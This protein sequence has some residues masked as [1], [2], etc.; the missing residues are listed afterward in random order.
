ML[1]IRDFYLP[2]T[3]FRVGN[4]FSHV[5]LSFCLQWVWGGG[6]L[7]VQGS[8]SSSPSPYRVLAPA[9]TLVRVPA[10]DPCLH[11]SGH[12]QTCSTWTTLYRYS[13]PDMFKFVHKKHVGKR[14][15]GILLECFPVFVGLCSSQCPD[16][17]QLIDGTCYGIIKKEPAFTS[18][19]EA[20]E[21][22]LSW[23][24]DI[25][26]IVNEDINHQILAMIRRLYLNVGADSLIYA[27]QTIS[28]S[29][30]N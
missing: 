25:S 21:S 30:I 3:K 1:F 15:V 5:C 20:R 2:P 28:S 11:P 10:L 27:T 26:D 4:V 22:C 7:T 23:N 24:A 29:P 9:F 19:Y 16:N 14:V 12:V 13:P 8:G 18:I 6:V 17:W